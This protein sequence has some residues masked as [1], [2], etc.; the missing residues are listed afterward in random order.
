[1]PNAKVFVE[2]KWS[3]FVVGEHGITN[4]FVS[5]KGTLIVLGEHITEFSGVPFVIE[6]EFKKKDTEDVPY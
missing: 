1:M 3:A 4:V 6:R 5:E 2:G